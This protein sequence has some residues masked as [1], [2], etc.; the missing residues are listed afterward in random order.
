MSE[1]SDD[2]DG[3]DSTN[4]LMDSARAEKLFSRRRLKKPTTVITN[5]STD[6]SVRTKDKTLFK[7]S[8]TSDSESCQM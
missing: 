4:G 3:R 6:E 2:S 7:V 1:S 8:D 5:T